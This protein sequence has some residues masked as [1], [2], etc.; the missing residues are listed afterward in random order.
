MEVR[1]D[2]EYAYSSS[3]H[4]YVDYSL[5]YRREWILFSSKKFNKIQKFKK[6]NGRLLC[7]SL[8]RR[9]YIISIIITHNSHDHVNGASKED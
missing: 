6:S 9:S 5:E 1:H 4:I 7:L 2:P 8:R 3:H